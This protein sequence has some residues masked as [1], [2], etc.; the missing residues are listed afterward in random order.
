MSESIYLKKQQ[1]TKESIDF[2]KLHFQ[3]QTESQVKP[4]TANVHHVKWRCC[5]Q[6]A[7]QMSLLSQ[8]HFLFLVT[9]AF[10][11]AKSSYLEDICFSY[12]K[13]LILIKC[14]METAEKQKKRA[15]K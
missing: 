2:S 15:T 14:E 11:F 10:K 3:T 5:H 9:H 4:H 8:N 12:V 13:L 7:I 6:L 1:Q